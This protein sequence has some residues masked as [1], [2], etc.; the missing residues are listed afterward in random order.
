MEDSLIQQTVQETAGDPEIELVYMLGVD[1]PQ[2]SLFSTSE[3][4]HELGE[5]VS[6]CGLVV[7][8]CETQVTRLLTDR[9]GDPPTLREGTK[10]T[11]TTS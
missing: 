8:G 11:M 7:Q 5:L 2:G 3:S 9:F 6:Q 4:L 1:M 10:F